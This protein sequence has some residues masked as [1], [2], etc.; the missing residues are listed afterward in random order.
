MMISREID[1]RSPYDAFAPLAG[2]AWAHLLHGGD[3]SAGPGWSV[4]AAFPK[5]TIITRQAETFISGKRTGGGVLQVLGEAVRRRRLSIEGPA[6]FPFQSGLLGFV[7]YEIAEH[8][9]P[10]LQLPPSPFALP[11]MAFGAYDAVAIFNRR[12]QRAHIAGVDDR[13]CRRLEQALGST[14]HQSRRERANWR[15]GSNFTRAQYFRAVKDTIETI[16]EGRIFQANLS[17]QLFAECDEAVCAFELFKRIAR[18][19]DAEHGAL[20]QFDEGAIVSNSPERF[21]KIT[22]EGAGARIITEPIKG[23]RPRDRAPEIDA[24]LASELLSDPKDRAENIMIVDLMRN[25]LSKICFDGSIKEE[26]I[27]A[28]MSL[29]RVHHLVS[30]ISGALLPGVGPGEVFSALFPSGSITGAPKIEAI[31]VIAETE[32]IG[33]GP[34]YGAIGYIDDRGGADFSVAIRTLMLVQNG[35]TTRAV[36]PVGGGVT[37]RSEPELE[38]EETLVKA[39]SVCAGLGIGL[40]NKF[41]S[42]YR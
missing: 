36:F 42:G 16:R 17:Q 28:L 9:E 32:R 27:C 22:P 18:K 26:A 2:K 29:S 31:K 25:D 10:S 6:A 20:L 34:F 14:P 37:L 13:A 38:Y 21:F 40:D 8:I 5:E 15:A 41:D 7:G 1:W 3:L 33:R 12:L 30:R 24:Q 39:R 35:S 19:S 11:D 4:I 23:T